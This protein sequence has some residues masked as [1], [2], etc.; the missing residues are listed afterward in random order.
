MLDLSEIFDLTFNL[1]DEFLLELDLEVFNEVILV[2]FKDF[3]FN[4]VIILWQITQREKLNLNEKS[5][6]YE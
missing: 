1:N 4:L 6:L 2:F 3:L 5:I